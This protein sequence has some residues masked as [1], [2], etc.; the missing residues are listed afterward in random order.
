V[1][2]SA[3]RASYRQRL[4][5]RGDGSN[6]HFHGLPVLHREIAGQRLLNRELDL[7]ADQPGACG[8]ENSWIGLGRSDHR[9]LAVRSPNLSEVF[10]KALT[11]Y[12]PATDWPAVE[13]AGL[14]R[15]PRGKIAVVGHQSLTV[16]SPIIFLVR[17]IGSP[18]L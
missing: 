9:L 18:R 11:E 14:T 7:G 4:Q 12:R 6:D 5:R 3:D 1:T 13:V 16:L 15:N 17:D 8:E 10:Q 2:G